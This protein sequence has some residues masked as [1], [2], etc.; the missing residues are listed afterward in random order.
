MVKNVLVTGAYGLIGGIVYS[1]LQA[2]P[3]RY[4]A[5]AMARRR[6]RS[7]RVGE[8]RELI[9]SDERFTL[10][11][12][13]DLDILVQALR[14]I[15]V[16][17]HLAAE[18]RADAPWE[19]VLD[20]NVI[21]VRNVFEA[22]RIAGVKRVVYA[23]SVMVSWGY[24]TE[25]PYR[26]I[27]QGR[28]DQLSPQDVTPVTHEWPTRP[29]SYYPASKVWGEALGRVYADVHGLSVICVRIGWVNDEDR[30]H[31]YEWARAGWCSQR[32]VVQMME[33]SIQ[34][35]DEVRFDIFYAMSNNKWNWVDIDHAREVLDTSP[36][37]AQ[38]SGWQRLTKRKK[39]PTGT[40]LL[41]HPSIVAQLTARRESGINAQAR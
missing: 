15:D 16:V 30:P 23:S 12:L 28:Y 29:T 35:P 4:T 3:E 10:S 40:Y 33:R 19:S 34:A 2:R 38:R 11:D 37:T 36:R 27:F 21:G 22:A 5:Y 1:H 25:E 6:F 26:S 14:G 24:Q 18:P 17:V 31:T 9:I 39:D 8:S 7:E 13:S 41:R 32:D 20:S